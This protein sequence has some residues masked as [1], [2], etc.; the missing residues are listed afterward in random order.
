MKR[1]F[2]ALVI[3]LPVFASAQ[4]RGSTFK[5]LELGVHGGVSNYMGDLATSP[6]ANGTI[7]YNLGGF[8]RYNIGPRFAAKFAVTRGQ[9]QASDAETKVNVNRNLS[10]RSAIWEFGLTGEFNIL[11]YEAEGLQKRI[12]PYIFA[13]IAYTTFSPEAQDLNNRWV[14][15]QPLGTEGQNINSSANYDLP[16]NTGTL[17]IPMGIGLKFAISSNVNI[18]F[19]AGYR[20]TMSDYM[21][22][23]SSVYPNFAELS[24]SGDNGV[25]S[26]YFSN[27]TLA[28]TTPPVQ[29]A[30][31]GTGTGNDS[32]I[33]G[34]ISVSYNLLDGL[35]SSGGRMGCPTF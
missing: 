16:Y 19:E 34:N 12:A 11:P 20:L 5:Y 18:G 24:T 2:L 27:R 15:L 28:G 25:Q 13:G 33:F 22:D 26:L 31:R 29:G 32:Y 23:V 6:F 4:Y 1:L 35:G 21:D 17:A 9:I 30:E 7:G 3:S 14:A 10:F 8:A